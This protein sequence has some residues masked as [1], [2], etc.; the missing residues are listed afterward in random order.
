MDDNA[1][2]NQESNEPEV[3]ESLGVDA[4]A[5]EDSS[6]ESAQGGLVKD[7]DP[8]AIKKRL[9]QQA[10]KHQREMRQM[11]EQIAS[12]Q[13]MMNRPN[14]MPPQMDSMAPQNSNGMS[15]E[16]Q[17]QRGVRYALQA[18]EEQE[19][20]AKEAERMAHVHRQYE[21]LNEEF[22]K[23]SDKYDDFDDVVR[24]H[25]APFSPAIRDALLMVHNPS[26]VAYKLGK[27]RQD[28]DRISKLH[29]LEQAR[30]VNKLSFALMGG[31]SA[32]SASRGSSNSLMENVKSKPVVNSQP[33]TASSIRARMKAGTWK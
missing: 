32:P 17:I 25:D 23:A 10:K 16:E 9:G 2:L 22:D 7:S 1:S 3:M 26:E 24:G 27:N 30:E 8:H 19:K 29:P 14:Q 31:N 18:R 20:Q 5:S 15:I 28:L 12:M 21:R 13:S 33:N 11:Q 4:P 6:D